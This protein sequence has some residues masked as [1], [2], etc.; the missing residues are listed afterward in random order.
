MAASNRR[1]RLTAAI[2]GLSAA[3]LGSAVAAYGY[4]AMDW[5]CPSSAAL[6]R[7]LATSGV[8]AAFAERGL[9]L[10][11]AQVPFALPPN[12]RAYK[13][14]AA[15]ATLFVIVCDR[16]CPQGFDDPSQAV[17]PAGQ[18]Q[19]ERMRHGIGFLNVDLWVTDADRRSAD[20]L[21]TNVHPVVE[22]LDPAPR[23]NDRC[24][25]G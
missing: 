18:G 23:P 19:P 2:V 10:D 25:T 11:S 24:Y 15:N 1:R 22:D 4:F 5:S 13:H 9:E 12:A 3:A 16:R 20:Q 17:F 21:I 7:P 6:E 14:A 8:L